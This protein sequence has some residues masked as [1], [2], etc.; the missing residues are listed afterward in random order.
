M[1]HIKF[2]IYI[3]FL[4]F[5]TEF[6]NFIVLFYLAPICQANKEVNGILLCKHRKVR[7]DV[8]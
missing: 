1:L 2:F 5:Y 7:R 8:N 6:L 4:I 3:C